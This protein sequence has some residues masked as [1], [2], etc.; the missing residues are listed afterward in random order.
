METSCVQTNSFLRSLRKHADQIFLRYCEDKH[1]EQR[2]GWAAA[3]YFHSYLSS[4]AL[5]MSLSIIIIFTHICKLNISF[6]SPYKSP[7]YF[8]QLVNALPQ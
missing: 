8:N 2:C 1:A 6:L 4:L 7:Y 3:T 5:C